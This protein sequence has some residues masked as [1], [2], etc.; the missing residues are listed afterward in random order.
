MEPDSTFQDD[1]EIEQPSEDEYANQSRQSKR[2]RRDEDAEDGEP[3]T[4]VHNMH[5]RDPG[6]FFKLSAALKILM[7]LKLTDDDIST[8]DRLLRE[9]CLE[10]VE[11]CVVS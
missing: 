3:D 8:A 10:L 5:P 4:F 7:S 11:V 1:G 2:R 6:H 9:Y